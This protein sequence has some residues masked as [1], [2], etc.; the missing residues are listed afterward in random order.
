MGKIGDLISII[1]GE[2]KGWWRVIS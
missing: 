1:N 2:E